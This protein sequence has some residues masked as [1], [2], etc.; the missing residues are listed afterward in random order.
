MLFGLGLKQF[1]KGGSLHDLNILVLSQGKQ[2]SVPADKVGCLSEY[3]TF[4]DD[5]VV[6]IGADNF[7]QAGRRYDPGKG[8]DLIGDFDRFAGA[9]IS[10]ELKFFPQFVE[11]G[12]AG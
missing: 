8:A 6:G 10:F 9:E 3:G 12:F 7:Q 11:N 2:V 1:Q 5:V 4:Q